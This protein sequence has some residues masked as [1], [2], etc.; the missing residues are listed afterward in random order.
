MLLA[1]ATQLGEAMDISLD[2]VLKPKVYGGP[3]YR[4]EY[5]AV[6]DQIRVSWRVVSAV[7]KAL[8]YTKR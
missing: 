1:V 2:I 3:K 7:I 6:S 4:I 8:P 5:T